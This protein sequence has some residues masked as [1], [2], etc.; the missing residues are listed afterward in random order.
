MDMLSSI[1]GHEEIT[2]SSTIHASYLQQLTS[3]HVVTPSYSLQ[4]N[5]NGVV[6]RWS[7]L[8]VVHQ[9]DGVHHE[10]PRST[11]S[12]MGWSKVSVSLD[13]MEYMSEHVCA[14]RCISVLM[15]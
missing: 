4:H 3:L 12:K 10:L 8:V 6:V 14:G 9:H 5:T 13:L 15:H 11:A 7:L 1:S 2:S